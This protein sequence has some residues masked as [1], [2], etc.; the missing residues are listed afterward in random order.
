[1]T[2][3]AQSTSSVI[4]RSNFES[5]TDSTLNSATIDEDRDS[6]TERHGVSDRGEDREARVL[7]DEF[8]EV[9]EHLRSLTFFREGSFFQHLD[10]LA[11]DYPAVF[12]RGVTRRIEVDQ[13]KPFQLRRNSI[14]HEIVAHALVHS[15]R[16]LGRERNMFEPFDLRARKSFTSLHESDPL[17]GHEREQFSSAS[18]FP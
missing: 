6:P 7:P 11:G 3:M 18:Q 5:M 13:P 8:E 2:P 17:H 12:V 9:F 10:A 4:P 15:G 1:M 14:R 16:R